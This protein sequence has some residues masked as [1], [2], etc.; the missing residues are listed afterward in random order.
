MIRLSRAIS[1]KLS[2]LVT[3]NTP[4]TTSPNVMLCVGEAVAGIVNVA[5]QRLHDQPTDQRADGEARQVFSQC[6]GESRRAAEMKIAAS[7]ADRDGRRGAEQAHREHLRDEAAERCWPRIVELQPL[8]TER[9]CARAGRRA[10]S[11]SH[12]PAWETSVA[13]AS[14]PT[15]TS[16]SAA[17]EDTDCL[18]ARHE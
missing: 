12:S 11:G 4:K 18:I 3:R 10:Q 14:E 15:K 9:E 16:A 7:S 8:S 1:A 2:A 17:Q 5:D 6:A 13:S